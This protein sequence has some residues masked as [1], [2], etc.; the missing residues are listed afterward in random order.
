MDFVWLS[1]S[2]DGPDPYTVDIATPGPHVI[3]LARREDGSFVDKFILTT[4]TS[5]T[6]TGFG[7]PETREGV[8]GLPTVSMSA[9]TEGKTFTT[10]ASVTLSATATGDKGLEI[11]RIQYSANGN[12]IGES[13]ASPFS[14]TW[15]NVAKWHLC[16]PSSGHG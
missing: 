11:A 15:N 14:V 13:S 8:P 2:Q 7:P 4:Q 3:G 10:G 9:P 12:V 5:F 16:H 1:D 6:P